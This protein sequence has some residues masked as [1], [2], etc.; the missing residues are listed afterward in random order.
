MTRVL[1]NLFGNGFYAANK[2]ART[3]GSRPVLKVSTSNL[4]EWVEIRVRDNGAGI[5]AEHRQKLF[6][7]SSRPSPPGRAPG[8]GFRSATRSS[9]TSMAARSRQ[10]ASRGRSPNSSCGFRVDG[11]RRC[12]R[13]ERRHTDRRRRGRCRGA[14]PPA[15]PPRRAGEP[16]QAGAGSRRSPIYEHETRSHRLSIIVMA[17]AAKPSRPSRLRDD[18]IATAPDGASR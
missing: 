4:G 11:A 2:K 3:A 10:R 12:R 13:R 6:Q 14:V 7:P 1:L 17:S 9:L 5:S 8:S 16:D 18:E 15:L